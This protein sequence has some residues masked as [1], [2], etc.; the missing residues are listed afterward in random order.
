MYIIIIPNP[1]KK[2]T[3]NSKPMRNE[4]NAQE[5]NDA[6]VLLG[7]MLGLVEK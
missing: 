7:I 5:S 2:N 3:P 1:K 4:I 6:A